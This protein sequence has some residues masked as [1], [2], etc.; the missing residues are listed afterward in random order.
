MKAK[1]KVTLDLT[2]W[3]W[4]EFAAAALSFTCIII[5][6]TLLYHYDGHFLDE[7]MINI[8]IRPN[9]LASTFMTIAKTALLLPVAKSISQLKWIHTEKQARALN[10]FD[11]FDV[12]SRGP[13]GAIQLLW[14]LLYHEKG[15]WASSERNS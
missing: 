11:L 14:D 12:A 1:E 9:T 7:W 3:W 10:K 6:L 8:R 2:H 13:L 4:V 5:L 15:W